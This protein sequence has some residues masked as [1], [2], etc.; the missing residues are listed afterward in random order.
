MDD[1]TAREFLEIG[2]A[3]LQKA[4]PV[5]DR[6]QRYYEGDQDLPFAPE[7]VNQEYLDL[8]EMAV[9]NW[10]A[11]AMDAPVQRLRSDGIKTG[12]GEEADR[13][14]WVN[15]WQANKFDLRQRIPYLQMLVHGR[16]LVSVWPNPKN[17]P[18]PIVRPENVRRVHV[19]MD[20]YDP[21]TPAW[22]VK[23]VTVVDRS[24][25]AGWNI[26]ATL[27]Q[28]VA[29]EVAWVYDGDRWVR[30]ER[31]G[32]S[33]WYGSNWKLVDDGFNPLGEVPFALYDNKLDADGLPH[34]ALSPLIPAQNA[35][36][37]IRFNTLLAM[38]FSAFRQRVFVGYDPIVRDENGNPVWRKNPDGSVML[39]PDGQP[40]PTI[41]SP[42]RVGVDRALVF[43]GADTKVFD[44]AESNLKN[45]IEALGEF[46]TEFFA[47]G[48]IPPQYLLTR[49]ANLSGDA[50]AGAESTLASLVSDLQIAAGEGHE[51]MYRLA[52]RA[53]GL[54]FDDW[55]AETIWGD[56]EAKSFAQVVD[57]IVKLISQKFP[58]Q[59]AF[60]MLPGATPQKVSTW[61]EHMRDEATD[62]EMQRVLDALNSSDPSGTP[63]GV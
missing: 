11:I 9:A 1:A 36:N 47:I 40:V 51:H 19:E 56:G 63:G 29:R 25:S 50:L 7:G 17:R 10:L 6:R 34:S 8:R 13:D 45:Y 3:K 49:M 60:A 57:A 21:F 27:T 16:G 2:V 12:R 61:M 41:S 58:R 55:A 23:K 26:F 15:V 62:P 48:Q 33:R 52:N 43:P 46:L 59:D 24:R 44:L 53:R 18:R 39:G 4:E 38:Q 28:A 20:P 37:T 32:G 42:G 22:A 35:I 30:F 14:A 31:T 5:F 54:A